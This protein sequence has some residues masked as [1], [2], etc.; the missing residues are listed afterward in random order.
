MEFVYDEQKSALLR[1]V[2]GIGFEEIIEYIEG[3]WVLDI[4]PQPNQKK[5]PNQWIY[6]IAVEGYVFEVPFYKNKPC[7]TLKT[8]YPSRKATQKHLKQGTLP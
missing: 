3:G 4:I 5:H 6:E 8:L 1:S 7:H 2:R